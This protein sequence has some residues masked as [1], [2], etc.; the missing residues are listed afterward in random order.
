MTAELTVRVALDAT[1]A[2]LRNVREIVRSVA[3][4]AG[5]PSERVHDMVMA[6]G[7][8]CANVVAH[9]YG[10]EGGDMHVLIDRRDDDLLFVVSDSGKP[11]IDKRATGAGFGLSLIRTLADTV[12]IEGPGD[13]GTVVTMTFG[14]RAG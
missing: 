2:Q 8:A 11:V 9:A 3:V 10:D 13:K 5:A 4:A 1:P 6:V 14:I 7:E 12:T